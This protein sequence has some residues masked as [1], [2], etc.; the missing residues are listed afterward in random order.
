MFDFLKM[1]ADLEGF[2]SIGGRVFV[3]NNIAEFNHRACTTTI[4]K[5]LYYNQIK[6]KRCTVNMTSA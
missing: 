5:I 4:D 6:Y 3:F 1:A 2:Q